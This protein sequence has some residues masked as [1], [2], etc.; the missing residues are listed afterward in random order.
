MDGLANIEKFNKLIYGKL[1]K[2]HNLKPK[3]QRLKELLRNLHSS[4]IRPKL[5]EYELLK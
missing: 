4:Q 5:I 2:E 1:W 3:V